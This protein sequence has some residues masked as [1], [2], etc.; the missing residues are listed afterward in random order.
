MG[1]EVHSIAV[2]MFLRSFD[3][4]STDGP[5]TLLCGD[6]GDC[7]HHGRCRGG[8]DMCGDRVLCTILYTT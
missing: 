2:R 4:E 8:M 1:V 3:F 7:S 5:S 6:R